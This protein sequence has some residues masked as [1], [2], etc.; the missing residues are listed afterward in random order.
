[1]V[2]CCRDRA[3]LLAD[4]V[5]AVL[6]ELGPDDELLVVDSASLDSDVAV[7]ARAAGARVLRCE[8]PGASRAR[9]AG[10]RATSAAVVLF[11]DDDCRPLPGWRDAAV[12]A[13]AA[14]ETGAVWGQV[15][16]DR[17]TGI[18][19]SVG[20]FT[21]FEVTDDSDLSET[22]HGA[23]MAFRRSALEA[24]GGFDI[25]LGAG[26]R[27][28]GAEDKDAFWRVHRAGFGARSVPEM[29]VT[30]VVHR[31]ESQARRVMLSYGIGAGV[32]AWKR[33]RLGDRRPL[34]RS[35]LWRH[36]LLPAVRWARRGRYAAATGALVRAVG[37]LCGWWQVRTWSVVDGHLVPPA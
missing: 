23:A 35:E 6:A 24:V 30:H 27:F 9:N 28:G 3:E 2:I 33:A 18:A 20:A 5:P 21:P 4:A 12:K 8:E 13:L 11:T 16:A 37:V 22:G 25:S 7:V 34:V 26:A 36:G 10:W 31:D 1:M 29:A 32:L 15:L 14:P 19:L 17:E